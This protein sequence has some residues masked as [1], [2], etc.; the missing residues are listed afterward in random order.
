M[1]DVNCTWSESFI[2]ENINE[3]SELDLYWLE[4]PVWPPEN[5]DFLARLR[6]E[7]LRIACGENACTS[8]QFLEIFKNK[9]INIAQPSVTKVGGISELIKI[10]KLT[11]IY[12]IN[13]IP[14]APYFGPGFL[15]SLQVISALLPESI[16]E[17][18]YTNLESDP[19]N[20]VSIPNSDGVIKIPEGPGL[21]L[22]P[23]ITIL[24]QFRR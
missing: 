12:K 5:Y 6:E 2:L 9:S 4:E 11:D 16:I 20:G 15:A 1:L 18:L 8:I 22:D 14:H 17:R 7:G 24:D 10:I 19:Y 3:I 21:G 13:I 23:D